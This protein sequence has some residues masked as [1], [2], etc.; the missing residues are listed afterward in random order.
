MDMLP[1]QAPPA[2]TQGTNQESID[3]VSRLVDTHAW[4]LDQ[5]T[6]VP[7]TPE[8]RSADALATYLTTL[9]AF[10]AASVA[11]ADGGPDVPRS[12]ALASRLA[13][14]M[15]D[16]AVLRVADGTLTPEAGELALRFARSRGGSLPPG[17]HAA[18]LLLDGAPDIGAVV[19]TDERMQDLALLFTPARGWD[20]FGSLAELHEE[21]EYR[22]NLDIAQGTPPP[23]VPVED[24]HVFDD[25]LRVDS[26]EI[27]GD[28]FDAMT[29]RLL[30]VQQERL[31]NLVADVEEGIVDAG[32][33]G[34]HALTIPQLSEWL[35]TA[36]L[37]RTRNARLAAT[38]LEERMA[39]VPVHVQNEWLDAVE[40]HQAELENSQGFDED[41]A[42]NL[43]TLR[44]F[45]HRA[46]KASLAIMG[47]S[48]DPDDVTISAYKWPKDAFYVE[49]DLTKATPLETV[50]LTDLALKNISILDS[51]FLVA[52][53]PNGQNLSRPLTHGAIMHLVRDLDIALKYHDYLLATL[54]TSSRGQLIRA[55]SVELQRARMR[56][57][58]AE[59]HVSQHLPD[60]SDQFLPDRLN[61]GYSWVKAIV[62][63]PSPQ[64]RAQVE[65]HTIVA[66]QI[67]YNGA[68]VNDVLMISAEQELAVPN[69]V[70]YTPD[71]PDGLAFREFRSRAE[72]NAAFSNSSAFDEYL[73][74][75]LPNDAAV[76]EAGRRGRKFARSAASERFRWVFAQPSDSPSRPRRAYLFGERAIEGNV[77]EAQYDAA[78][79]VMT[80]NIQP[81]ART[82]SAALADEFP[83]IDVERVQRRFSAFIGRPF[84]AAWRGYDRIKEGDYSEGF[85]EFT[86]AY[87][88]ALDYVPIPALKSLP[89]LNSLSALK[90]LPALKSLKGPAIMVRT[91][92]QSRNVS[93]TGK[94]LRDADTV[95]PAAYRSTA[96]ASKAHSVERGIHYIDG[97]PYIQQN[98]EMYAAR[99]DS[100]NGTWRIM[101]PGAP[102]T[103]YAIPVV[104]DSS[105]IWRFNR[106]VGLLGGS[107]SARPPD[108]SAILRKTTR[109]DPTTRGMTGQQLATMERQLIQKTGSYEGAQAL[110]LR[111]S[112]LL[113]MRESESGYWKAA[114]DA[115]RTTTTARPAASRSMQAALPG[116]L[117]GRTHDLIPV[118]RSLWP[119]TVRH[120]TRADSLAS[121]RTDYFLNQS[122]RRR[123]YPAGVYVTTMD[124]A[125]ATREQIA[126]AISGHN[127]WRRG[128]NFQKKMDTWLELDTSKLPPGTTI[129]RVS[130]TA[131]GTYV[132]RPPT[133]TSGAHAA[134]TGGPVL[135]ALNVRGAITSTRQWSSRPA[136]D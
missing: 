46:V 105:G 84:N 1:P 75:R 4:L 50:S 37:L 71:A 72:A 16:E 43:V 121:I 109:H 26:R 90:S 116:R 98:R 52:T 29:A 38:L 107:P 73:L 85:L 92:N 28:P 124:P 62:D 60:E 96:D 55:R 113:P 35:D 20:A 15:R 33:D 133:L 81:F 61:R 122:L 110:A 88:A 103:A 82:S 87:V 114:S 39:S 95:F 22:V 57:D 135:P 59:A 111:R 6:A 68:V 34:Q 36:S 106:N 117:P 67:T 11:N 47:L 44:D 17:L 128:G 69:V 64:L 19:V 7:V 104:R 119:A 123:N 13:S 102:I 126:R 12:A 125:T 74:D 24:R 132:V 9:D 86:E 129:Y 112:Q 79:S 94:R 78:L 91:A 70:F 65:R 101:R 30:E 83:D 10:W 25:I 3:A 80:R 66:S 54:K 76:V 108:L 136:L 32:G 45:A 2:I 48:L 23:V 93:A 58:L 131:E 63:S 115:A 51:R 49:Q 53:G 41:G 127:R 5:Q 130:N 18:E 77:F 21:T 120:F 118:D 100:A 56:L 31:R 42:S 99:F 14:L 40:K 8:L 27:V 89:A 97:K 134:K